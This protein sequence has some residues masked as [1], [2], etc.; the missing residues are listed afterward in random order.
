MQTHEMAPEYLARVRATRGTRLLDQIDPARTAHVVVEMKNGFMRPGAL[1]EIPAARDVVPAIN[2]ISAALRAAGGLVAYT[3]FAY[4]ENEPN[5]WAAFYNRFLERNRAEAQKRA[6]APGSSDL[7]LWAGLDV[8]GADLVV[9]KTRY[10]AF[11]PGTCDLDAMLKARG[12]QTLVI[13][14]TMT[15]CCCESTARDAMQMG[16][17]VI[18]VADATATLTDLEQNATLM[19]M[20]LLFAE[21]AT[22]ADVAA[23]L[24]A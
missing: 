10:S 16:Y 20:A 14:G 4:L 17:D 18:F 8:Q 11:T 2:A 9:D 19:N 15:N 12:V 6:F 7:D 3:R 24:R 23:A 13:S 1:L 22:A 21:V 5:G